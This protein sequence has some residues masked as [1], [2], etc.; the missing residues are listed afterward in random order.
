MSLGGKLS[1][2]HFIYVDIYFSF[3]A[4]I[5]IWYDL[6][7]FMIRLWLFPWFVPALCIVLSCIKDYH[8]LTIYAFVR[9]CP[10]PGPWQFITK[11]KEVCVNCPTLECQY[12]WNVNTDV[13]VTLWSGA[14]WNVLMVYCVSFDEYFFVVYSRPGTCNH[15]Q[16][17][18][19]DIC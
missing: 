14:S 3:L 7:T 5:M 10:R 11:L 4:V 18:S 6:S 19:V 16:Y 1:W 17:I 13:N 15:R 9:L 8:N 2:Y 12:W